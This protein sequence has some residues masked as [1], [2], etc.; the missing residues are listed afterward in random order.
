MFKREVMK[1][2]KRIKN[3][4]LRNIYSIFSF[5][6]L[7][8]ISINALS[9][10]SFDLTSILL[11]IT[12]V[13]IFMGQVLI[14]TPYSIAYPL[15]LV[16]SFGGTTISLLLWLSRVAP[17]IP[18]YL[19]SVFVIV[20]IPL[21]IHT[22]TRKKALSFPVL[23]FYSIFM[24]SLVIIFGF[25]GQLQVSNSL[26]E[27]TLFLYMLVAI[28]A[29]NTSFR[30]MVL[31][32]EL[33]IRDKTSFL[34]KAKEDLSKKFTS[35]DAQSEIDLLLYYLSSSLDSFIDGDFQRSF[36]DAFKIVFDNKREAFKNIYVLPENKEQYKHFAE[37]RD[38]LSH[39][40]IRNTKG[41]KSKEKQYV[42][43]I[44]KLQKELFEEN[45]NLLKIVRFDFINKA[46]EK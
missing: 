24:F 4:L 27:V 2:H 40:H 32:Q 38:N 14:L 19:A 28:F 8:F 6:M 29:L 16:S 36:I 33:K 11:I 44:N 42:N 9:N 45:L 5:S 43:K 13:V 41:E 25:Q 34:V 39:A 46:L 26:F 15:Y 20:V 17:S 31:S 10:F 21:A 18:I 35:D 12:T 3:T 22:Y 7:I 30:T 23:H 37:I 1:L